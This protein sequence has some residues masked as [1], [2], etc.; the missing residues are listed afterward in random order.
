MADELQRLQ[1]GEENWDTKVNKIIDYLV[2]GNA[3]AGLKITDW[4]TDGIVYGDAHAV[5]N[6]LGYRY[7]Q[8][9]NGKIVE[10]DLKI[11]PNSAGL[12]FQNAVTIPNFVANDQTSCL[13][14]ASHGVFFA[15]LSNNVVT[16]DRTDGRD[17]DLWSDAMYCHAFYFHKD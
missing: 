9:P 4:T 1:H 15:N 8:L 17:K 14:A 5:Q 12:H 2:Q 7:V 13:L 11:A 3:L 10:V 6:N 16:L